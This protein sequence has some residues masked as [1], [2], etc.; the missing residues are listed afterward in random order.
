MALICAFFTALLGAS[1]GEVATALG[2]VVGGIIGALGAAAAVYLTLKVQRDDETEKVCTAIITEIAQFAKFPAGQLETC[3]VVT[4]G[5][6]LPR[7]GLGSFMQTPTPTIY[8]NAA[9]AVSRL[10]RPSLVISF[11]LGLA[12]TEKTVRVILTTPSPNIFLTPIDVQGLGVLLREQCFIA[13]QILSQSTVPPVRDADFHR[14]MIEGIVTMLDAEL[15][16]AQGVFPTVQEYQQA[17]APQ[18]APQNQA[19]NP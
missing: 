9:A 14:Q 12:E 5:L 3:R 19:P 8:P 10:P 15:A 11:Y 13:R 7:A 1:V 2:S 18:P 6:Q 4:Q 16:A 17:T